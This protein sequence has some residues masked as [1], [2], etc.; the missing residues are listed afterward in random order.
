MKAS[1]DPQYFLEDKWILRAKSIR[2]AVL[3]VLTYI[4]QWDNISNIK[5]RKFP[6][7]VTKYF[8]NWQ[9]KKEY[10][11]KLGYIQQKLF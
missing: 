3:Q 8:L 2:M 1:W 7:R 11:Y 5:K 10:L 4:L 9:I 6:S